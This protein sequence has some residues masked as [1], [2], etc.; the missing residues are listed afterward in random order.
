MIAYA[1]ACDAT[2][3]DVDVDVGA[4]SSAPVDTATGAC[5][6]WRDCEP[7][8]FCD[9]DTC[10]QTLGICQAKSPSC[11]GS[12]D[13][14]LCGCDGNP[15][16][17]DCRANVWGTTTAADATCPAEP[18]NRCLVDGVVF[19]SGDRVVMPGKC[20]DCLCGNGTLKDCRQTACE[21]GR[22]IVDGRAFSDG[23]AIIAEGTCPDCVCRAGSIE[24]C[25]GPNCPGAAM[26]EFAG[27]F[28][29]HGTRFKVSGKGCLC[30]GGS[31]TCTQ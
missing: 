12:G 29:S 15:Y 22:C 11:V 30:A 13:A 24:G 23:D 16:A 28:Y 10:G 21:A 26:C 18:P 19:D 8:Y 2:P 14:S 6:D 27:A 17:S 9:K 20:A 7:G 4:L 3:V 5:A 31:V 1:G 25:T